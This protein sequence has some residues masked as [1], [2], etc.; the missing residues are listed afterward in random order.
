MNIGRL[1][2]VDDDAAILATLSE[3]FEGFGHKVVTAADGEEA[4]QKFVP[5]Q[6]D[7]IISDM[8]MPKMDGLELLKLIK[9]SDDQVLF[10]IITGYPKI[11]NAIEA[12]KAGAYDYVI[13][14]FNLED[15]KIKVERAIDVKRAKK[16]LKTVTGLLWAVLLSIPLW[17]A[18]GILMGVVWN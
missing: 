12:I 2:I 6:F 16:S 5:G 8:M 10:V 17:L 7:C 15:I 11:E 1:L 4:V 9:K 3:Y 13:K 14:P 18:L